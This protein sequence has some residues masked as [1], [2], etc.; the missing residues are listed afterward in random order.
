MSG[1]WPTGVFACLLLISVPGNE[2]GESLEE[3][4]SLCNIEYPS[5]AQV[6]W[7]CRRLRTGETLEGL[8]GSHWVDVARYN[9]IDRRHAHPGVSL[10]IPARL[11]AIEGFTP[12]PRHYPFAEAEAKF[13]LIDLVEQFLGAYEYGRLVISAPITTGERG[14]ETPV[15]EF[16]VTASQRQRP[17]SL[18]QIEGTEIPYPMTFALKFHVNRKGVAFWIH[19]RDLPGYP[20]SHGC[21]GLYDETMQNRYYGY[22]RDPVLQDALTLYRWVVGPSF[23]EGRLHPVEGGPRVLIVGRAP[24]PRKSQQR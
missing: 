3:D 16:R 13:I 10:K 2:W 8:F 20:A 12:L 23:D 22:P 11:G 15:E 4:P 7:N 19:G 1:H 21:V 6:E 18:Y 17:S 14:N 5:D 9:R 24:L